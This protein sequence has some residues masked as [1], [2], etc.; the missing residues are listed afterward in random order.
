MVCD[1]WF[2]NHRFKFQDSV[3]KGCHDLTMLCLDISD[4]V[5]ITLKDVAYRLIIHGIS[6]SGP[7]DLFENS[8]L[9]DL[10]Y[11]WKCICRK[12]I[13]KIKYTTIILV[14]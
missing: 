14:I 4:I 5:V 7:I 2:F 10:G 6:K 13:L 9:G 8:M 1:Y 11:I 3:H 12:S